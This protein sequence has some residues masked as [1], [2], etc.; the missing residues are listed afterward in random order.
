ML[1]QKNVG[2]K[3]LLLK[4]RGRCVRANH[5]HGCNFL[6]AF[7]QNSFSLI[8]EGGPLAVEEI[9]I[10]VAV[11]IS[12]PALQ[13]WRHSFGELKLSAEA[14]SFGE[15]KFPSSQTMLISHCR[16]KQRSPALPL[17]RKRESFLV[18]FFVR[19]FGGHGMPCP[20]RVGG[21]STA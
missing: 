10:C 13:A 15:L 16:R 1:A 11:S 6:P 21:M 9:D 14:H 3:L 20:Y 18:L 5:W 12:L 4:S 8:R 7:V 19:G 2:R 17:L